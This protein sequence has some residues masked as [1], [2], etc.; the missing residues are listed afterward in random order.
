M[1]LPVYIKF[2][3]LLEP[4]KDIQK[5][6]D[7][8]DFM[9]SNFNIPAHIVENT[10]QTNSNEEAVLFLEKYKQQ[11]FIDFE[12]GDLTKVR[13]WFDDNT[14]II[15]RFWFDTINPH[16]TAIITPK[17]LNELKDY[18]VNNILKITNQSII[19]TNETIRKNVRWQTKI[20]AGTLIIATL[21]FVVSTMGVLCNKVKKPETQPLPQQILNKL[22]NQLPQ[23]QKSE[24]PIKIDTPHP[25]KAKKILPKKKG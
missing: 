13:E 5:P 9:M 24:S 20:L 1:A 7:I 3:E 17:G 2:L 21:S 12:E 14:G 18:R 10:S 23:I 4:K 19:E 15:H 16:M 22:N 11:Q 6:V 25:T 8:T